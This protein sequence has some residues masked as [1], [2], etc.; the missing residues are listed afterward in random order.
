MTQSSSTSMQNVLY[1][2]VTNINAALNSQMISV[3]VNENVNINKCHQHEVL[4]QC[5][6]VIY[7]IMSTSFY[8][9][10]D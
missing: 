6:H 9:W 10:S 8:L 7:T 5:M 4:Q 1:F 3:I 2:T